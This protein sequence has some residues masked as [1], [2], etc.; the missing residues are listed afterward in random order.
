MLAQIGML[1]ALMFAFHFMGIGMIPI[2]PVSLTTQW[3]LITIGAILLGPVAGAV[4]GGIFGITVLMGM[5]LLTQIFLDANLLLGIIFPVVIRGMFVGFLSGL[6]FRWLSALDKKGIWSYEAT[7]LLTSLLNTFMFIA[8]TALL[9]GTNT[10]LLESGLFSHLESV[11]RS[12]IFTTAFI[13]LGTQALLEAA[14]CT[15]V[16]ATVARILKTH[17]IKNGA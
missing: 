13:G 2:G 10:R 6:I 9:F 16:A 15:L 4:L 11:S 17:L 12:T 3:V 7:G 14:I 5:G 8:G 1:A